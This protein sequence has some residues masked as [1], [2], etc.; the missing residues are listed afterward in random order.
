MELLSR[1]ELE[2]SSL[3]TD[4]PPSKCLH[5]ALW[6]HFCSEKAETIVLSAP[7]LP[8]ARFLL[9]VKLWV[10]GEWPQPIGENKGA[11]LPHGLTQISL[12]LFLCK[13]STIPPVPIFCPH[14]IPK[15]VFFLTDC[16]LTAPR[17]T[18]GPAQILRRCKQKEQE[19]S[20][21]L[22][23]SN[24]RA[25]YGARLPLNED[26]RITGIPAFFSYVS[27]AVSSRPSLSS[28][29]ARWQSCPTQSGPQPPP[30]HR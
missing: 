17:N 30:P 1:F 11:A 14:S 9:W 3:P 6:G 2:T 10:M 20:T 21:G 15:P 12:H 26:D 5:S 23:I 13:R 16:L 29:A 24:S 27:D 22:S 28:T 25:P 18:S 7:L 19:N 4:S 8:P